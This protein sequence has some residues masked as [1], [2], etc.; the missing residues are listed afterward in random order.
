MADKDAKWSFVCGGAQFIFHVHPHEHIARGYWHAHKFM[1]IMCVVAL[2][3]RDRT[4]KIQKPPESKYYLNFRNI[5]TDMLFRRASLD[6]SFLAFRSL[7]S[8]IS[9]ISAASFKN[10]SSF[11][12]LL[13]NNKYIIKMH[14]N[15]LCIYLILERTRWIKHMR[16]LRNLETMFERTL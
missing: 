15:L 8:Q 5:I 7:I 3:F 6:V 2:K 12:F 14:E 10:I 9:L 4:L 16:L 11:F 1:N 13:T